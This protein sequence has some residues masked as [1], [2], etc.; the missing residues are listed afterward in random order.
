M[1]YF[2][3]MY[4][5]FNGRLNRSRYFLYGLTVGIIIALAYVIS[6]IVMVDPPTVGTYITLVIYISILIICS[7]SGTSLSIRRLHDLDKTGWLVL[8]ELFSLIP[9][10]RIISA[11]FSLYLL[12]APGTKGPNQYGNDPL[13]YDYLHY[14]D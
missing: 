9:V 5:S 1:K 6:I 12:F 8:I 10:L 3:E 4:L 7:I 13:D 11:I 2:F 14:N